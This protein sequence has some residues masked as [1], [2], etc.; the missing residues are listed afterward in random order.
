MKRAMNFLGLSA[1]M[2]AIM[3]T[4]GTS[5][6][7]NQL[8]ESQLNQDKSENYPLIKAD[9]NWRKQKFTEKLNL[10]SL[11]Q[12]QVENIRSEYHPQIRSL[13]ENI[14]SERQKL[15]EMMN[16]N[17]S[18]DNLRSQHTKI[19]NLD[20]QIHN[21]R[22]ESMLAIR[23]VLT[24]QQRQQWAELMQEHKSRHRGKFR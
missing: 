3:F 19:I 14:R 17:E 18:E 2:I 12:A 8:G 11:Q 10:T 20:Q 13:R 16:N 21:L 23:E 1:T 7:E 9:K 5:V 22:F 6:A 4:G 15:A 24:E